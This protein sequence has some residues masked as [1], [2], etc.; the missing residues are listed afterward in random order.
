MALAVIGGG[1]LTVL[2]LV[3]GPRCS[4]EDDVGASSGASHALLASHARASIVG[5]SRRRITRMPIDKNR[6]LEHS[7]TRTRPSERS[8]ELRA[9]FNRSEH[10]SAW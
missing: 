6:I 1:V 3:F 7:S 2:S 10:G 8:R 4:C 5:R 9:A